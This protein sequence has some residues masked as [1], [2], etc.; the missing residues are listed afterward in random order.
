MRDG[1]ARRLPAVDGANLATSSERAWSEYGTNLR[2]LSCRILIFNKQVAL[3]SPEWDLRRGRFGSFA[4]ALLVVSGALALFA[5]RTYP[6][7]FSTPASN[8]SKVSAVSHHDQR[9]RFDRDGS[10][11]SALT[12]KVQI[13]PVNEES[14]HTRP[15]P[16]VSWTWQAEG[17]HYNRPPP[18]LS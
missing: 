6:P 2:N 4:R 14:A 9:P 18:S 12:E 5:T 1:S 13:A 17:I 11:W 7:R 8:H 15:A 3:M 16:R 10:Q